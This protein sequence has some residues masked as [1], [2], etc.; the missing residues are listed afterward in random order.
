MKFSNISSGDKSNKDKKNTEVKRAG[1][2]EAKGDTTIRS[3]DISM[4][5]LL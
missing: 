1:R 4:G 3:N 2:I 5:L